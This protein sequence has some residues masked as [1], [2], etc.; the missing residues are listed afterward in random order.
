MAESI[1]QDVSA[2]ILAAGSGTRMGSNITKQQMNICGKSILRH[3]IEAY[4]NAHSIRDIIV[5]AKEDEIDFVK[6]EIA[7]SVKPHKIISG[8]K[9]RFESARLGFTAAFKESGY[10]AIHDAARCLI[11]PFDID[12]VS[13]AA[14]NHGAASAVIKMVDTVKKVD[15]DGYIISTE[16]RASLRRAATPQIFRKDI[17]EKAL[18][19]SNPPDIEITDDNMLIEMIGGKI[20]SVDCS[21]AN[22]KITEP[23]DMLFAKGIIEERS[24]VCNMDIRI[25][26]GYDV[27]K[28]VPGRKMIIG[29]VEI[30][31]EKGFLGHSDADVLVHA[32]MD[33]LLGAAALGDIGRHFP[34]TKEEFHGISSINLLIRVRKLIEDAGYKISNID[35]T[36]ILQAP[37]IAPFVCNMIENI[38][39]ALAIP[40]ERVNIKATTE[41]KLGFTGSG[42]GASAHAVALIQK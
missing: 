29:G 20:V 32:V 37:K 16:N 21:S 6:K 28:L 36:L 27:H 9:T 3:T 26:H 34:D 5:V 2:V 7:L 41:E 13:V 11:T 30:P 1:K 15:E 25:G 19:S 33:A 24:G 4:E 10:I 17:Y 38:S 8:G 39:C 35:A 42:D 14:Y 22:I 31:Y 23:A 12:R 40:K 18:I